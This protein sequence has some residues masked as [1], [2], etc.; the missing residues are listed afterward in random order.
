[1]PVISHEEGRLN[2]ESPVFVTLGRA[3]ALLLALL[4]AGLITGDQGTLLPAVLGTATAVC[5][6]ARLEGAGEGRDA[7]HPSDPGR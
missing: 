4:V 3:A 1:L 2:D 6:A 7:Y 5:F